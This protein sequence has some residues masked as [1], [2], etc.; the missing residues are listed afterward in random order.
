M[1]LYSA[2]T[3]SLSVATEPPQAGGTSPSDASATR[4]V[5]HRYVLL[6]TLGSGGM[7]DVHR[8]RDN[9]LDRVVAVKL[10]R[11]PPPDD[12]HGTARVESEIHTLAG[13]R[14]PGLVAVFDAGHDMTPGGPRPYLVMEMIDGPTLAA[15]IKAGNLSATET[16]HVARSLADA[17]AYVHASGVIHRDV[18]P[19]NILLRTSDGP[20]SEVKLTDFGVARRLSDDRITSVGLTVGTAN[21]ISPEQLTRPAEVGPPSDIYA[22]G[23]TLFECLTGTPAYPGSGVEAAAR[24]LTEPLVVPEHLGPRWRELL[25]AMTALNPADRPTAAEVS[26]ALALIER[27]SPWPVSR[28]VNTLPSRGRPHRRAAP[29]QTHRGALAAIGLAAAVVVAAAIA[30]IATIG[31]VAGRAAV[32]GSA[33]V[34]SSTSGV[35]SSSAGSGSAGSQSPGSS[36]G[37]ASAAGSSR[38]V[39]PTGSRRA[40]RRFHVGP[41]CD[42]HRVGPP[43][44]Q[45][46]LVAS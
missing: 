22:L 40:R 18:K 3:G 12:P 35:V 41:R 16:L 29:P 30:Y 10:F 44:C 31:G 19:A 42:A 37:A 45:C 32:P 34:V 20:L 15:G 11:Q 36:S 13:L 38:A 21:Y 33:P 2:V 17:L 7:A 9:V 46:H 26:A 4:I 6:E 39:S 5:D 25:A 43:R 27:A 14:H 24:R 1:Q 23:L 28:P 8:A